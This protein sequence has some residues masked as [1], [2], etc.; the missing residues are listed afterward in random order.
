MSPSDY[1]RIALLTTQPDFI[2]ARPQSLSSILQTSFRCPL[3]ETRS[4]PK[5]PTK[6]MIVLQRLISVSLATLLCSSAALSQTNVYNIGDFEGSIDGWARPPEAVP[7][8]VDGIELSTT[9]VTSGSG[10]LKVSTAVNPSSYQVFW[11]HLT[12]Y[13]DEMGTAESVILSFDTTWVAAEWESPDTQWSLLY[14]IGYYTETEGYRMVRS[15]AGGIVSDTGNPG[16][17]GGWDNSGTFG[18]VH[19]RTVTWDITTI[20]ADVFAADQGQQLFVGL[21][22]STD[23]TAGGDYYFDNF[24]LTVSAVPEPSTYAAFAGIAVLGLANFRRRR[25]TPQLNRL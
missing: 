9:G 19:T 20:T 2:R 1:L 22:H 7:Q 6:L 5:T 3:C 11:T 4:I 16:S 8:R 21:I 25:R 13:A 10:S 12:A 17:P 24:N 23:F 15:D 14:E 18:A